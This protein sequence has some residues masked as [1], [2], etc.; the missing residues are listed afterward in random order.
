MNQNMERLKNPE[1][2]VGPCG[3]LLAP[4]EVTSDCTGHKVR[5]DTKGGTQDA[6]G[7]TNTKQRHFSLCWSVNVIIVCPH[8]KMS[9]TCPAQNEMWTE[10]NRSEHWTTS[11]KV[12][13][14]KMMQ[15]QQH[16]FY[17]FFHLQDLRYIHRNCLLKHKTFQCEC[18]SLQRTQS[19]SFYSHN[20]KTV[21]RP[22]WSLVSL[23]TG[24]PNL[25]LGSYI[26]HTLN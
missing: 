2:K 16:C 26:Q 23:K 21:H 18:L 11:F 17:L 22:A 19:D 8:G 13:N 9:F 20:N 15:Q 3:F 7:A 25:E 14:T 1:R 6:D 10:V 4:L 12:A 24:S 5:S